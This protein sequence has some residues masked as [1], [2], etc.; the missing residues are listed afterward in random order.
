MQGFLRRVE[1]KISATRSTSAIV[2]PA[3]AATPVTEAGAPPATPAAPLA[4]ASAPSTVAVTPVATSTADTPVG[5]T[6]ETLLSVLSGSWPVRLN[7]E[8]LYWHDAT[9]L[10]ILRNIKGAFNARSSMCHSALVMA[11]AFMHAG[12]TVDTF[13]RD[14]LEWLKTATNWAMFGATASLGVIHRG[15]LGK[16]T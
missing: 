2:A 7:L 10:Q 12:T 4:A 11:N 16:V 9:D 8:F 14:N 6:Y 3:T 1:E 15:H 5:K 13:L